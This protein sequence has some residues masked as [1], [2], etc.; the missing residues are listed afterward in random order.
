MRQ[1]MTTKQKCFYYERVRRSRHGFWRWFNRLL[2]AG[3]EHDTAGAN[4]R[5]PAQQ[6]EVT[7]RVAVLA[8]HTG[9]EG[10]WPI[11][12]NDRELH[13][14]PLP[15]VNLPGKDAMPISTTCHLVC[16]WPGCNT[17]Q[18]VAGDGFGVPVAPPAWHVTFDKALCPMHAEEGLVGLY[19]AKRKEIAR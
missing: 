16:D 8:A 1:R 18:T 3:Y 14:I 5:T 15:L 7:R 6:A 10:R 4:G 17:H 2:W 12:W 11:D 19:E 13:R 9:P